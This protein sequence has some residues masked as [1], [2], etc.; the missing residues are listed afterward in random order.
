MPRLQYLLPT[1]HEARYRAPCKARFRLVVAFAGRVSNPLDCNERFLSISSDF[2]PSQAYAGGGEIH[3]ARQ[4]A[5]VEQCR[6]EVQSERPE[7]RPAVEQ[8]RK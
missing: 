3:L 8:A 1:L 4:L 5:A 7:T 2:L 6:E